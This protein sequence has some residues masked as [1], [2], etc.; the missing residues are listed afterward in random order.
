MRRR[1]AIPVYAAEKTRKYEN[2]ELLNDSLRVGRLMAKRNSRFA[3]DSML[4]EWDSDKSKPDRK[5]ISD[6]FHSDIIDSVLYC[7]RESPAYSYQPPKP[8]APKWGTPEWGKIQEVE[9]EEKAIAHFKEQ[10]QLVNEEWN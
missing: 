3:S 7:F 2:I 9:M 4:L 1:W 6:R 5:V 10:E 8:A